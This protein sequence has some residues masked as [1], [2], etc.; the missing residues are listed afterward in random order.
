MSYRLSQLTDHDGIFSAQGAALALESAYTLSLLLAR[1]PDQHS[2]PSLLESYNISRLSRTTV[3]R[4]RSRHMHDTCQLV[5]GSEQVERDR[6]FREE[7]PSEGFPNPWADPS[8][9]N[10]LWA[11]DAKWAA[12]ECW[13]NWKAA[14]GKSDM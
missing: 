7:R 1:K 2:M 4:N 14:E 9:Q 12:D 3:A 11:Y 13:K 6:V 8:F 5:D 10:F